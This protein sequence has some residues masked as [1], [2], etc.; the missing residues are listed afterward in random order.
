MRIAFFVGVLVMHAVRGDP[1]DRPAFERERAA[2]GQKIF[3][4]VRSLVSAMRQQPVIAHADAE[5]SGNPIQHDGQG[6][7][8]PRKQEK[9]SDRADVK[10]EHEGGGRPVQRPL[11]SPVVMQNAHFR[12]I[13]SAGYARHTNTNVACRVE[14]AL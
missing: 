6:E 10:Q 14:S 8:L 3:N 4:P 1:D 7:R 11:E 2:N 12:R 13:L 9:R 5:A